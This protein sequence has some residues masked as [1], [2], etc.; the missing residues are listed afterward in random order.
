[1]TL[2]A[3]PTQNN[4][5]HAP[6]R[7][8]SSQ[9]IL[10]LGANLA[11]PFFSP[12]TQFCDTFSSDKPST[13]LESSVLCI[14]GELLGRMQGYIVNLVTTSPHLVPSFSPRSLAP[15]ATHSIHSCSTWSMGGQRTSS[16]W[17][18]DEILM[19]YQEHETLCP[20]IYSIAV[21]RE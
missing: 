12:S 6:G 15:E 18:D 14:E 20:N 10:S 11:S 4:C 13:L 2:Q 7:A 19:S 3:M 16:R 17:Y 5:M 9:N 1:M 21:L 8:M